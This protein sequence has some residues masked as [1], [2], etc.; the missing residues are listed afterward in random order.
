MSQQT[1]QA[2]LLEVQNLCRYFGHGPGA[3]RAV[4]DVTFDIQ[5]GE[6]VAVVGESGSGK[7]T[8]GRLLLRLLEPSAGTIRLQ[9]KEVT[10]KHQRRNVR[11]YWRQVQAVFQDPFSAFNQFYTIEHVLGKALNILDRRISGKERHDRVERALLEVGLD[12]RDVLNKWPHQLSGGQ[13]QRVMMARALVVGPQLLIADE[14]TS[15]LDA[16]LRVTVLNQLMELRQQHGMSILFITHDLGQAYYIS[17]RILVMYHGKMVEQ[18][19]V[20]YV[21]A[22]PKHDYTKRLLADVPRMRGRRDLLENVSVEDL[23]V[24]VDL[25][26]GVEE[27]AP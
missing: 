20:E 6:I 12:P 24:E 13:V 14:P 15:M 17:D 16:S 3:V 4:D 27:D 7:T 18:G 26:V 25:D 23:T 10:G 8:L 19:P 2:P 11:E 5:P 1:N 9:G 21:L 22:N